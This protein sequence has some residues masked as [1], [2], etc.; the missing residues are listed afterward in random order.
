GGIAE[1]GRTRRAAQGWRA[2]A[3]GAGPLTGP[4]AR[5]LRHLV[6]ARGRGHAHAG[7]VGIPRVRAGRK[8]ARRLRPE[9]FDRVEDVAGVKRFG[10]VGAAAAEE[11]V[12]ES[13]IAAGEELIVAGGAAARVI[14]RLSGRGSLA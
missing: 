2:V 5:A 8:E 6:A 1:E 12:H 11:V 9:R 4:A 13:R 3:D 10:A 14:A 7:E